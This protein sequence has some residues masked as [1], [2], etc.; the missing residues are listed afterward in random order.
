MKIAIV[1]RKK[2]TFRYE[3]Y[4]SAIPAHTFTTLSLGEL[5]G[6]DA[7]ILP[8]GG[9]ITPAFFGE[10]N[11]GSGDIDT[12]LDILQIQ[13]VDF[14]IRHHLPL[15]GICKGMQVI[16]VALGGTLIQDLPSAELH[17]HIGRDQHHI[18]TVATGSFLYELYG[19]EMIV[20]SAHH[21]G[22][23]KLGRQLIPI[24]WCPKDHCVEAIVHETLPI[25]GVQWHPE[26]L[27]N[28][29]LPP[30]DMPVEQVVLQ[31]EAG[32]YSLDASRLNTASLRQDSESLRSYFVSLIETSSV[33]AFS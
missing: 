23:G 19:K 3:K 5:D 6:C 32:A 1:G 10:L 12:E 28:A 30:D 11:K 7:V 22:V 2:D 14:C 31:A 15:L 26:R 29:Y 8:G 13:T 16:N 20:N 21:Q 4:F 33:K 17:K 25:I 18:T 27:G 24:Q 9:D